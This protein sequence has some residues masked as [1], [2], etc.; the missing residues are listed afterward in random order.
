[1]GIGSKPGQQERSARLS[2][3]SLSDKRTLD[4]HFSRNMRRNLVV[5]AAQR[6]LPNFPD[7]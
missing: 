3:R 7:C 6:N 2:D 4:I 5:S 1:L